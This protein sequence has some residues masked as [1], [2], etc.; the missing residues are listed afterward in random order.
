M[1]HNSESDPWGDSVS[2]NQMASVLLT[3]EENP[4]ASDILPRSNS[5]RFSD[6]DDV[7][8]EEAPEEDE[9]PEDTKKDDDH[10]NDTAYKSNFASTNTNE[11]KDQLD[12]VD[13]GTSNKIISELSQTFNSISL[14]KNDSIDDFNNNPF[15]E[16]ILGDDDNNPTSTSFYGRDSTTN[17]FLQSNHNQFGHPYGDNE[18][19]HQHQDNGEDEDPTIDVFA[20]AEEERLRKERERERE[21]REAEE[22]LVAEK[23]AERIK[24]KKSELMSALAQDDEDENSPFATTSILKVKKSDEGLFANDTKKTSLDDTF[25]E[26][27]KAA[28]DINPTENK[29]KPIN[30]SS[31]IVSPNRKTRVFVA[32]RGRRFGKKNLF[33]IDDKKTN[34][35]VTDDNKE[36]KSDILSDHGNRVTKDNDNNN[37]NESN[38]AITNDDPLS[39]L[40]K[41]DD[42]KG[43]DNLKTNSA[44][45]MLIE[46]LDE[47]LFNM[48][49]K[50]IISHSPV[51]N[52]K[53]DNRLRSP[54]REQR[55]G[56]I[57]NSKATLSG[58]VAETSSSQINTK[59]KNVLPLKHLEVSV[60]DPIKVGELTNAHVVYTI[61]SKTKS[62]ILP[63]PE[64][65]VVR[66]YRDFLWLYNQLLNNHPGYIVP[67]PPEKQVYGRFDDKFIENRRLSLEKMLVKIA[68]NPEFQRDYDFLLF[69]SSDNFAED[70]KD[71]D[72]IHYHTANGE[73]TTISDRVSIP[74]SIDYSSS[75]II[76]TS[77]AESSN[78]SGGGGFL[79]SLSGAFSLNVSKYIE[80]DQ[81][82]I[83]TPGYIENLDL[84]LRSLSKT[85]DLILSQR[86][87]V[88]LSLEELIITIQAFC[89]L[90]VNADLSLIFTNFEELQSKTKE[91]LERTNMTQILTIGS[92]IDEY[93]RLIGSIRNVLD[94][95]LKLCNNVINLQSQSSK[96]QKNLIKIKSKFHN[97]L[98]KI[99]KYEKEIEKLENDISKETIRKDEVSDIIRN[100]LKIFENNKI[101]D[102][103]SMVE[104]YWE[105]LCESQK[106]LIELWESFYEKCKFDDDDDGHDKII[107]VHGI[108][109][110]KKETPVSEDNKSDK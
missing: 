44:K 89:D 11:D 57:F 61:T 17:G 94:T 31:S 106:E 98:D 49:K 32:A 28:N 96:K 108:T 33:N 3:Q 54:S 35:T 63:K 86:E 21:E 37:H 103:R 24:Q 9:E 104:I 83:D 68:T 77:A 99:T 101:S 53:D 6:H 71:R 52:S 105:S 110:V 62:N 60:G 93:I 41:S 95:R 26:V 27:I 45:E 34:V 76:N 46:S 85:L 7:I 30:L 18:E 22:K 70:S 51:N 25:N 75:S 109:K 90:E 107:D 92:T 80:N 19:S 2:H 5:V 56:D 97:Q 1:E 42:K 84:Q 78:N 38:D 82:F 73:T 87:D 72:A 14:P 65:N 43:S 12:D 4:Y 58:S 88:I 48:T 47:P 13:F 100:E 40:A 8:G 36:L 66:R 23:E 69:L 79:S 15:G 91:L 29:R 102:F 39:Q 20:K 16:S 10:D 50:T 59:K 67:P 81:F 55:G 74:E 64:T